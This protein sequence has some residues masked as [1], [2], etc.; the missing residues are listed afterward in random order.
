MLKIITI[1]FLIVIDQLVKYLAINEKLSF[2]NNTLNHST[3]NPYISW[4]IPL[5]GLLLWIFIILALGFLSYILIKNSFPYSLL[6]VTAGAL[7]NIIDR[8]HLNCIID[9]ISIGNFPTFNLADSFI[10]I[11]IILFLWQELFQKKNKRE[12]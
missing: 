10:T 11:G 12:K 3:C 5:H 1:L 7:G 8:L 6:L 9:F 4:N 2:L